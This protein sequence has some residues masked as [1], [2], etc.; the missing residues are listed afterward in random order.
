MV[1][2]G[3]LDGARILPRVQ[4]TDDAIVFPGPI[5]TEAIEAMEDGVDRLVQRTPRQFLF[6]REA[7][8][9]SVT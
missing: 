5:L 8:R 4:V 9:A 1:G 7:S 6:A 3:P 2:G